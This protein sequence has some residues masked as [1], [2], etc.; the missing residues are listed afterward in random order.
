MFT[1]FNKGTEIVKKKLIC[2]KLT[3]SKSSVCVILLIS[4]KF[5]EVCFLVFVAAEEQSVVGRTSTG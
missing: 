1:D 5:N 2:N 4:R 3:L